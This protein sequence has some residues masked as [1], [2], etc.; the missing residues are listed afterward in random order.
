MHPLHLKDVAILRV[1]STIICSAL[2]DGLAD[3]VAL[4]T[5]V[6]SSR[7]I[8]RSTGGKPAACSNE[9][10]RNLLGENEV[11]RWGQKTGVPCRMS[12]PH[13]LELVLGISG[14]NRLEINETPPIGGQCNGPRFSQMADTQ[15]VSNDNGIN[16]KEYDRRQISLP[17][18]TP[19]ESETE[20][21]LV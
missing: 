16:S 6:S 21:I 19:G 14:L 2:G 4:G 20:T 5:P 15:A 12:S 11:P 7:E 10:R 8:E 17:A 9:S 1:E 3:T 18:F 13:V